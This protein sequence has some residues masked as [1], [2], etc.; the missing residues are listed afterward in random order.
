[1]RPCSSVGSALS[2]KEGQERHAINAGVTGSNPVRAAN[3]GH[4][5]RLATNH[6]NSS[7]HGAVWFDS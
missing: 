4:Y 6:T 7:A 2:P 5:R 3:L 1:V